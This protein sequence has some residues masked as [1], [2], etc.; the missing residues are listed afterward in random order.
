MTGRPL[1]LAMSL[2]GLNAALLA[3]ASAETC[4]TGVNQTSTNVVSGV[5]GQPGTAVVTGV[6]PTF[7]NAVAGVQTTQGSF[8][9]GASLSTTSTNVVNGV[10]GQTGT[11]VTAVAPTFGTALT[12]V[13]TTTTSGS[14]LTN[15]ALTPP[16]ETR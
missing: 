12:S 6:T 13:N 9:T 3:S 11:A 16:L 7:A 10:S 8:L 4:V 1:L 14:F 5:S 2:A 15:A